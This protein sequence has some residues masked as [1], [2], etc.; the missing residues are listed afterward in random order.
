M[1]QGSKENSGFLFKSLLCFDSCCFGSQPKEN[2]TKSGLMR[3]TQMTQLYFPSDL[4]HL[5]SGRGQ[6]QGRGRRLAQWGCRAEPLSHGQQMAASPRCWGSCCCQPCHRSI[7]RLSPVHPRRQA[8]ARSH[9]HGWQLND[10]RR[11]LSGGGQRSVTPP[12]YFIFL[13][14]FFFLLLFFF[15]SL[16]RWEGEAVSEVPCEDCSPPEY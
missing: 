14:I 2:T 1:P 12:F 6:R 9:P 16:W 4:F 5:L 8:P 11:A 3:S 10:A 13:L 15:L 7:A